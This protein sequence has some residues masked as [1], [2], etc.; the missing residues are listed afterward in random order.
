MKANSLKL[1][2]KVQ[3]LEEPSSI[4][5]CLDERFLSGRTT[6]MGDR[7]LKEKLSTVCFNV[8]VA[9]IKVAISLP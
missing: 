6:A 9:A 5:N 1:S 4:M 7:Y 8:Q 2:E 3:S